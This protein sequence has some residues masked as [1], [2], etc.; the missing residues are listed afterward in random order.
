MDGRPQGLVDLLQQHGADGL[1]ARWVQATLV[2]L[3]GEAS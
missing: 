1:G 3:L 2:Q